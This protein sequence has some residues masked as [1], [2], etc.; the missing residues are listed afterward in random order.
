MSE[1]WILFLGTSSGIP[2]P[3]RGLPS[4]LLHYQGKY[5]LMDVGEGTQI[6]LIKHGIGPGRIDYI[7][8]THM[9]G[10]H[11][12]GLPGLLET[13]GM[14]ARS[15]PLKIIGPRELKEFVKAA[16]RLTEFDPEYPIEFYEPTEEITDDIIKIKGFPTCHADIQSYGYRITGYKKK[17]EGLKERFSLA[18]TGDTRPCDSYLKEIMNVDILIHDATFSEDRKEEANL[19]GHSTSKDAARMAL[20]AHAKILFLFHQSSRY[21][22]EKDLLIREAREIFPESYEAVDGMKFYF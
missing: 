8:I 1:A 3:E 12:F 18:Y 13:M 11:I 22:G 2:T 16:F 6:T 21:R 19:F 17:K 20:R 14:N 9:H 5:I 10:D 4:I 7:L 15:T